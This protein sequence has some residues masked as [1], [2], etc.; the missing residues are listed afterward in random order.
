[1]ATK[2]LTKEQR[3]I[4]A[5]APVVAEKETLWLELFQDFIGMLIDAECGVE[6]A[7]ARVRQASSLADEALKCYEE[8]WGRE[9]SKV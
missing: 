3:A 6:Y 1:M 9:N 7:E 2:R 8:R 4:K 5:M